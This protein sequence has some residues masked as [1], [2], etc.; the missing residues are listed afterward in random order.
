MSHHLIFRSLNLHLKINNITLCFIYN[1]GCCVPFRFKIMDVR[2]SQTVL[3][4]CVA[5]KYIIKAN[6]SITCRYAVL[7]SMMRDV[8]DLVG[9]FKIGWKQTQEC[10]VFNWSPACSFEGIDPTFENSCV[11]FDGKKVIQE[12]LKY[13]GL[14]VTESKSILICSIATGTIV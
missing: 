2:E 6:E 12:L 8:R 4:H 5:D 1:F 3:F 7:P 11:L 14:I 10:V 9:I 13:L